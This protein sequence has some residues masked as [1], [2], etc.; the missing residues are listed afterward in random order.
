M[1][2]KEKSRTISLCKKR[3]LTVF[4]PLLFFQGSSQL[5]KPVAAFFPTMPSHVTEY[6][7]ETSV[8]A[9][10]SIYFEGRVF[11]RRQRESERW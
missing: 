6:K 7:A 9:L 5:A 11:M 1:R 4:S 10:L 3:S 8:N 2:E